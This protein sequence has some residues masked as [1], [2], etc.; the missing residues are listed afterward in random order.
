LALID[1]SPADYL[2]YYKRATA[3]FSLKRHGSAQDDFDKVLSLTSN[4]FDN[5]HL[6]KARIYT[7]DGHFA[8]A[9]TSLSLYIKAKGKKMDKEA[10]ELDVE[11]TEGERLKEKSENEKKAHL[12][13]AC[14]ET[15][16]EAL[17]VASHSV[18]IRAWRAECALAAGD[19]ESSV[20]DL[21][22]VVSFSLMKKV[23]LPTNYYLVVY[24]ICYH[25]RLNC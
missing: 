7:R 24:L 18:E 2:L 5:A 21:T 17:R 4:T 19:V 1:Q 11:I 15:A 10:E 22:W 23:K 12:W 16:S 6:M 14:I 13:N 20:G 8:S 25:L 3:Y 9:R